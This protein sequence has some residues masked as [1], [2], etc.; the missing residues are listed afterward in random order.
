MTEEKAL[1]PE[2]RR[3][4]MERDIPPA[5]MDVERGH[6]LR[7]AEAIGDDNARWTAVAPPTFLRAMLSDLP[8]APELESFPQMLDGGSDWEYGEPVRVGDTVTAVTR[9]AGVNQR[10][11]G[12]GPA[13]F[14]QMETRYTN[15]HGD[16]LAT[17]KNT[18]IRY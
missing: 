9:F 2:A 13:V 14:L 10:S 15:Q 12:V 6:V 4:L 5:V 1:S 17:Q 8:A 18:L 3:A 7:F 11:I 16:W